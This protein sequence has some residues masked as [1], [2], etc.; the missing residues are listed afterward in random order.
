M[1]QRVI[2]VS[3]KTFT[4][5]KNVVVRDVQVNQQPVEWRM[6]PKTP[7][8]VQLRVGHVG[9]VQVGYDKIVPVH[10]AA[11]Y[12]FNVAVAAKAP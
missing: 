6:H 9:S 10:V 3:G 5:G 7:A 8:L 1:K 11:Y 2:Q 4:V 12:P